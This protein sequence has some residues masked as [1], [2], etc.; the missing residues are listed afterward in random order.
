MRPTR[1]TRREPAVAVLR[2]APEE[3]GPRVAH[4]PAAQTPAAETPAAEMTEP[5]RRVATR[6]FPARTDRERPRAPAA[7]RSADATASAERT[8]KRAE[9]QVRAVRRSPERAQRTRMRA[10]APGHARPD[11]RPP[12]RSARTL[13][14]E[15]SARTSEPERSAR[16]LEPVRPAR[17]TARAGRSQRPRAEARDSQPAAARPIR[18][19]E[20]ETDVAERRRSPPLSSLSRPASPAAAPAGALGIRRRIPPYSRIFP[21]SHAR[22]TSSRSRAARAKGA[23]PRAHRRRA[24]PHK[25]TRD[26]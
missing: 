10:G 5:G 13:E 19:K 22:S 1:P 12:E 8:P 20:G 4:K 16:T 3:G 21:A 9:A 18:A 2:R 7:G 25:R 11:A 24:R 15:R 14:P 26:T 17:R 6:R 23:R